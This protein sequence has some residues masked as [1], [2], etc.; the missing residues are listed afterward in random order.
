M[1]CEY[2][3][4]RQMATRNSQKDTRARMGREL[5]VTYNKI[6]KTTLISVLLGQGRQAGFRG[7]GWGAESEN[8]GPP[9][10]ANAP[11]P[12]FLFNFVFFD[13]IQ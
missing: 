1:I 5:C 4:I 8:P 13:F 2:L 6:G 11:A 3:S 7:R 9:P 10:E 12:F